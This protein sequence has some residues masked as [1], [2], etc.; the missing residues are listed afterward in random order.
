MSVFHFVP[1]VPRVKMERLNACI[2]AC[3]AF[4]PTGNR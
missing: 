3:S 4:K 1:P 2:A